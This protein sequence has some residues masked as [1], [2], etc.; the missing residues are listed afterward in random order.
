[1][2]TPGS[3]FSRPLTPAAKCLHLVRL[4]PIV[5]RSELVEATGLSQPTITR[6][7]TA[8]LQAGLVRERTDLTR[9]HGRGRPTVPLEAADTDWALA[10]IAVGTSATH[11]GLFDT[12]G[13]TIREDDV[14]T[15]VSKLT[16]NDFIETIMAGVHRLSAG[17]NRRL[18]SVGVTASGRV[19]NL[20]RI[21]ADNLGWK[22]VDI[23]A[24]LRYQ[25]GVPIVVS[26][27]VPA[28]LGSETQGSDLNDTDSV[29]VLFADDSIGAALSTPSGVD[30]LEPLP[31]SASDLTTQALIAAL[32]R[33]VDGSAASSAAS[34]AS[35]GPA[36]GGSVAGGAGAQETTLA[37]IVARGESESAVR[38]ILDKRAEKLGRL[39]AQLVAEHE[40]SRVVVAGSAFVDD[41]HAPKLFASTVRTE[42]GKEG[43]ETPE[44]RLIPTHEEIV[45]AIARAVALDPLL[46]T[47]L[48]LAHG[49]M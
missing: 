49:R 37:Q 32:P 13:R 36:G 4:N 29:L 6:A 15:P 26:S 9:S 12:H 16:E 48:D 25:F 17:L 21:W 28:I 2:L 1:M 14:A 43:L 33:P 5:T 47:P 22:G 42:L 20:G 19:D 40:P 39:A 8:L 45:R 30:Q 3:A 10:G 18:V 34:S 7:T 24:R 23:A 41:P 11:I 44:L 38:E 31:D 35:S 27:A 46:R